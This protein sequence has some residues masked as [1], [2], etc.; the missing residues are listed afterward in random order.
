MISACLLLILSQIC[1]AVPTNRVHINHSSMYGDN[2]I[3]T[4]TTKE[5]IKMY[6][7]NV[8]ESAEGF[9]FYGKENIHHQIPILYCIRKFCLDRNIECQCD[10]HNF[11]QVPGAFVSK[12]WRQ[13]ER[14][15][16][17]HFDDSDNFRVRNDYY[18]A[19]ANA[20]NLVQ[21]SGIDGVVHL[22]KE[23]LEV[24]EGIV[25]YDIHMNVVHVFG[26]HEFTCPRF[27]P[28]TDSFE[29]FDQVTN[30]GMIDSL[31]IDDSQDQYPFMREIFALIDE[32]PEHS[33]CNT[34]TSPFDIPSSSA[35]YNQNPVVFS[36]TGP[37]EYDMYKRVVSASQFEPLMRF[38][39][40]PSETDNFH[41]RFSTPN[42]VLQNAND[43][44]SADDFQG[45]WIREK[46]EDMSRPDP[47]PTV[48]EELERKF[49]YAQHKLKE[50]QQK[51]KD[52]SLKNEKYDDVNRNAVY[53]A[54][55]EAQSEIQFHFDEGMVSTDAEDV[56]TDHNYLSTDADDTASLPGSSEYSVNESS[57][58][59]ASTKESR[60]QKLREQKKEKE[61]R[62]AI[63]RAEKRAALAVEAA[64]MKRRE[65]EE[66]EERL[67]LLELEKEQ[68]VQM[69][70]EPSTSLGI[71]ESTERERN[72]DQAWEELTADLPPEK[73]TKPVIKQKPKKQKLTFDEDGW[74]NQLKPI[75]MEL[76]HFL[77][78]KPLPKDLQGSLLKDLNQSLHTDE[79]E[80][81]MKPGISNSDATTLYTTVVIATYSMEP[82]LKHVKELAKTE[83]QNLR[84]VLQNIRSNQD[85]I[86]RADSY[87]IRHL[88]NMHVDQLSLSYMECIR[89]NVIKFHSHIQNI[90]KIIH[91]KLD[92]LD[93]LFVK[94]PFSQRVE[95]IL[96]MAKDL[97]AE[98]KQN[99]QHL[100][101]STLIE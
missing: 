19:P 62:D 99:I 70:D 61:R 20:M 3:T 73:P 28:P 56:Q 51:Q 79:I 27:K 5:G 26:Y 12:L 30:G 101:K 81:L 69:S 84:M 24:D 45:S 18:P 23:I 78:Q 9:L 57:K 75:L 60:R 44:P 41:T 71:G 64:E 40:E 35:H 89:E 53:D 14:H 66:D 34:N 100:Q 8:V 93:E 37:S 80:R 65:R 74:S 86:K 6:P 10:P 4:M 11:N 22:I 38:T 98:L 87:Q 15:R 88:N 39:S 68:N 96:V 67:R 36:S 95:S 33:V 47:I 91:N 52:Q 43:L 25:F 50:Q 54:P 82:G 7:V 77:P 90:L 1:A 17:S 49:V 16:E 83:M 46:Q 59:I 55:S 31:Y 85:V 76:M 72:A 2:T 97:D 92:S 32:T 58:T 42:T 13:I 48:G 94:R 21:Y 29:S 63:K